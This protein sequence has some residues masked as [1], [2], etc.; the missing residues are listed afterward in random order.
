LVKVPITLGP[1]LFHEAYK[2]ERIKKMALKK[3]KKNKKNGKPIDTKEIK[4]TVTM[5]QITMSF[6]S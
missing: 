5:M 2:I 1:F 6:V 3:I 4:I